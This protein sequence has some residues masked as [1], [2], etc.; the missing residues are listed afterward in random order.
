MATTSFPSGARDPKA[1]ALCAQAFRALAEPFIDRIPSEVPGASSETVPPRLG[2]LVSSATNLGLSIEICLKALRAQ[3]ALP[4]P[5]THDLWELYKDLPQHVRSTVEADYDI[6]RQT[7]PRGTHLSV[8]L[9]KGPIAPPSWESYESLSMALPDLL[10]RTRELPVSWRY[11]YEFE[12]PQSGDYQFHRFE[13]RLL[14]LACD[15]LEQALA[16]T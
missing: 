13:Y 7:L 15:A 10:Q 8:T 4:I 16:T 6:G 11:I 3:L 9:A 1:A 2:N 5:R 14:L 12:E